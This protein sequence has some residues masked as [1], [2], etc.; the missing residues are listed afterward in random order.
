MAISTVAAFVNP[1]AYISTGIQLVTLVALVAVTTGLTLLVL[2]LGRR[3]ILGLA[4]TVL[5]LSVAVIAMPIPVSFLNAEVDFWSIVH[6]GARTFI[7]PTFAATLL[8]VAIH[9]NPRQE[10]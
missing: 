10:A 1:R 2:R 7:A 6:A 9:R 8:A 3:P 4:V 5:I